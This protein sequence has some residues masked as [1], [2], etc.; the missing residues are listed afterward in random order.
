MIC[1]P[2]DDF[3]PDVILQVTV[4]HALDGAYGAYRHEDRSL[5]PAMIRSDDS[6]SCSG[7]GVLCCLREFHLLFPLWM[8][9][10]NV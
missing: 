9:A 4:I 6:A 7:S 3:R 5:Y 1:V 10:A 2:E 8:A